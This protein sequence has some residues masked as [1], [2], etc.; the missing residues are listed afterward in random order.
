MPIAHRVGRLTGPGDS[1]ITAVLHGVVAISKTEGGIGEIAKGKQQLH[2]ADTGLAAGGSTRTFAVDVQRVF[3][4][5][6]E[7]RNIPYR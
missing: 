2:M 1:Q 4:N 7:N 3:Q 6:I 5:L